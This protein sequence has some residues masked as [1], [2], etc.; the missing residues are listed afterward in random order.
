MKIK[1]TLVA[2]FCIISTGVLAAQRNAGEDAAAHAG[3]ASPSQAHQQLLIAGEQALRRGDTTLAGYFFEHAASVA[4][5]A[6]AELGL[7]RTFMQM[8]EYRHAMAYAAHTAGVHLDE[9][10]GVALYAWLLHLGG[11]SR[12]GA[13]F[14]ERARERAPNDSMLRRTSVLLKSLSARPDGNFLDPPARFVPYSVDADSLPAS[15]RTVSSGVVIERGQKVLTSATALAGATRVWVRNGI[16]RSSA[17]SLVRTFPEI[18]LAELALEQPL[19]DIAVVIAVRSAYPGSPAFTVEF[20]APDDVAPAWPTLRVGF[21]GRVDPD[22]SG[23][24]SL[25][26]DMPAGARGGPVFDAAGRLIGVASKDRAGRD[27]LVSSARVGAA[28]GWN[29]GDPSRIAAMERIGVD[30]IYERAL[31]NTVQVIAAP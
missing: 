25:G 1:R 11:Q 2:L 15:A 27:N 19:Q 13:L 26:V 12:V 4:H 10:M 28:L 17:A 22:D 23:V 29:G 20:A 6:D 30:E 9:T 14:L 7:I 16:G 18:D 24:Y 31:V 5:T 3:D 8:G 21:L